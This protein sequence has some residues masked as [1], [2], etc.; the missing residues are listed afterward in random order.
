[1]SKAPLAKGGDPGDAWTRSA[2]PPAADL[3]VEIYARRELR[4]HQLLKRAKL[5]PRPFVRLDRR[6]ANPPADF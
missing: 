2:P 4:Y 5:V 1:M 6:T 3:W